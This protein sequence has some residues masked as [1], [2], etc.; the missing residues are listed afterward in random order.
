MA[1]EPQWLRYMYWRFVA[2]GIAALMAWNVYI[3][4][5][6]F[7]RY[8]LRNTPFRD[9]FESVFSVLSNGVNLAALGYALYTQPKANHDRR[10][11][12]GLLAT[13]V[14]FC[15]ILLLPLCSIDGW[16]SLAVA[17][18]ALC[19][20][21]AAAAYIQCS[22]FGI[23]ALLPP[24]CAEGYMS[25]QAIAGTVASAAQLFAEYTSPTESGTD[26][27]A[28]AD[29]EK[30]SQHQDR[31]RLRTAVYFCVSA[32]FMALSTVAWMQLHAR[33]SLNHQTDGNEVYAADCDYQ[34]LPTTTT[35]DENDSG[36]LLSN[37]VE[38]SPRLGRASCA[39][40]S[41]EQ[42]TATIVESSRTQHRLHVLAEFNH[43]NVGDSGH[44]VVQ[45]DC[46]A[47]ALDGRGQEVMQ[48]GSPF[49]E[50][51]L[52]QWVAALGIEGAQLVYTTLHQVLPYAY[53]CAIVMCQTL[54]VFPPLTE[55][56]VSSPRSRPRVSHLTAWHFLIFN[57]GDYLGRF[58]TRWIRINSSVGSSDGQSLWM[59]A[60]RILHLVN[61]ARWILAATFLL[62]PTSV[63]NPPLGSA[64][65][66]SDLLFL[67]LVLV[68]GWSNGWVA[69]AALILGPRAASNK[70]LAG[71][72]LGFALCAGL[73]GGALVSYPVLLAAGIS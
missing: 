69:T 21:A 34:R 7:F 37:M 22:I 68:L 52:P 10:I 24:C 25:G 20:A 29:L 65:L 72:I 31:L 33:L 8:E 26:M 47:T 46:N 40:C 16:V 48:E 13:L 54:A 66:H 53:I 38:G 28:P 36:A 14:A 30:L 51:H 73:A 41:R 67:F 59:S 58:S 12:A 39:H 70:E 63:A 57:V 6:D 19:A 49:T 1:Y 44:A 61:G 64:M 4:S 42:A 17:L 71:S 27:A 3:V 45:A 15:A 32:L 55:A 18:L 23:V 62:F 5:S 43:S 9:N 56:V 50:Q 35:E 60:P 11:R 2:L